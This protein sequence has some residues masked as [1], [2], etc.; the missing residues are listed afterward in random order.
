MAPR[1]ETLDDLLL[2]A[3]T[4]LT[5]LAAAAGMSPRSLLALRKGETA[6][7]RIATL[8]KLAAAIDVDVVRVRAA[9]DAT[10]AAAQ[11]DK[12]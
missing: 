2:K 10:R 4:P 11:A 3:G 7:P 1:A 6:T 12:R 5:E 9:I 8:T